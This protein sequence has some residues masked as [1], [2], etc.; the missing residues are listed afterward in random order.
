MK[1]LGTASSNPTT[2][3]HAE[4]PQLPQPGDGEA[5]PNDWRYWFNRAYRAWQAR[6]EQLPLFDA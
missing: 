2:P 3:E 4:V 5:A 6:Q 1:S